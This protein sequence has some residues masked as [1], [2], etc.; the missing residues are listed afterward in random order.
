MGDGGGGCSGLYPCVTPTAG[1]VCDSRTLREHS[2]KL[3][4]SSRLTSM[5]ASCPPP[6]PPVPPGHNYGCMLERR[7]GSSTRVTRGLCGRVCV[8]GRGGAGGRAGGGG[9]GA[10]GGGGSSSCWIWHAWHAWRQ[11][12]QG[13]TL[14]C[15]Q[16]RQATRSAAGDGAVVAAAAAAAASLCAQPS[17]FHLSPAMHGLRSL[18]IHIVVWP[19]CL[20]LNSYASFCQHGTLT[21]LRLLLPPPCCPPPLPQLCWIYAPHVS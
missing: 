5:L 15:S 6:P 9:G 14:T 4:H 3:V 8:G 19:T 12:Q 13:Q 20:C 7:L 17:M 1:C 21:F 16:V 18:V 10:G 11:Q 2:A